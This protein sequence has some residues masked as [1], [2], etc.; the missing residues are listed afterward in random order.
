MER[1]EV[2]M[3]T[4]RDAPRRPVWAQPGGRCSALAGAA[5]RQERLLS[6]GVTDRACAGSCATAGRLSGLEVR[7]CLAEQLLHLAGP[8]FAVLHL[9]HQGSGLR[10]PVEWVGRKEA[11][12][13]GGRYSEAWAARQATRPGSSSG[14]RRLHC[15]HVATLVDLPGKCSRFDS[16][17]P[18]QAHTEANGNWCC[19]GDG[20]S[21]W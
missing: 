6:L 15:L 5:A 16:A 10:A 21:C 18:W 2:G 12:G 1:T 3:R 13:F 11:G 4:F 20:L 7:P 19:T 8:Q 14:A 17:G 9:L